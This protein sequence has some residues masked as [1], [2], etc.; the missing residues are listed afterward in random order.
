ML[1]HYLSTDTKHVPNVLVSCDTTHKLDMLFTMCLTRYVVSTDCALA[2][3]GTSCCSV[4]AV[5][6]VAPPDISVCVLYLLAFAL[7]WITD[8]QQTRTVQMS[9]SA[10]QNSH[11]FSITT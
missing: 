8:G 4:P 7:L 6:T 3:Q 9:Q 1:T 5:S 2:D 10:V 11:L